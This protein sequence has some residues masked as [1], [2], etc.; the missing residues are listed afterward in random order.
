MRRSLDRG[1]AHHGPSAVA[2]AMCRPDWLAQ[3]ARVRGNL[4]PSFSLFMADVLFE[5]AQL[6]MKPSCGP[7]LTSLPPPTLTQPGSSSACSVPICCK[8]VNSLA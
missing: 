2:S 7:M 3:R 1:R 6:E 4:N 8:D 5:L